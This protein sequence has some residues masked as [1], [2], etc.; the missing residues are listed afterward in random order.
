M[1][2]M[3]IRCGLILL[4]MVLVCSLSTAMFVL[5][6][7]ISTDLAIGQL[8]N[9]D[10]NFAALQSWNQMRNLGFAID[11]AASLG[12]VAYVIY[13]FVKYFKNN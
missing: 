8:E 3:L 11:G 9:S 7:E 2:K 5:P 6:Y 13:E 12:G 1:K 10:A 4:L